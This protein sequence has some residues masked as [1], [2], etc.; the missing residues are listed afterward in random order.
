VFSN[1]SSYQKVFVHKDYLPQLN[2]SIIE[3]INGLSCLW[4]LCS[5]FL[6]KSINGIKINEHICIILEQYSFFFDFVY[7]ELKTTI[8]FAHLFYFILINPPFI[9]RHFITALPTCARCLFNMRIC[10]TTILKAYKTFFFFSKKGN[11][12]RMK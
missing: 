5:L 6:L 10:S 12:Q 4:F 8:Y 3:S 1:F 2:L 11:G 9:T 7:N